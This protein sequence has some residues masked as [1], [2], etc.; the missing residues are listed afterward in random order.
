[1][2]R[3]ARTWK[4][5]VKPHAVRRSPV[6]TS[7]ARRT[8]PALIVAVLASQC[9]EA[10]AQ[11]TA[12]SAAAVVQFDTEFL[13]AGGGRNVDISRFETGSA[14][15]PGV[16]RVDVQVNGNYVTRMD[17]DF[18]AEADGAEA[19][20]RFDEAM[21][22]RIGVD[23][24]QLGDAVRAQL[25]LAGTRLRIEDAVP[26]ATSRFDFGAQRLD[27][28]VPQVAMLRHARGYVA[29]SNWDA[30]VNAAS[31]GY[32]FNAYR[33]KLRHGQAVTQGYL[34]LNAGLNVAGWR[35]R[36][37]GSYSFDT[38]GRRDYQAIASYAKREVTALSAELTVGEAF[39][40]GEL[41]DAVGFRGIRL[42]TDDRMLPESRRGY[43]PTVRGVAN[44]NA[45]VRIRQGGTLIHETTVAAGAF[46]IDD[47][48]A[49]GYGGDLEVT[50]QEADGSQRTFSVPF[51]AVPLSLR[52]GV[53]RFSATLGTLRQAQASSAPVFA[54]ATWQRGLSNQVTGYAGAT[55]ARDYAAGMLG[56][57]LNTRFGA[58]GADITRSSTQTARAGTVSGASYRLSYARD[59]AAT[60]TNVSI[61]AYR[62]STGGFYGLGDAMQ[63]REAARR[64]DVWEPQRQRNRASLTLGQRLGERH[65]R[66]YATASLSDYWNRT[67]SDVNYSLGYSG[68]LGRMSY[69]VSANRQ[70]AADGRAD[71]QYYASLTV[72]LGGN[73][74][75]RTLSNNVSYS[76]AGRSRVQSTLSGT[77][78]E[79]NQ[80]AYGMSLARTH[81]ANGNNDSDL[82]A[83][84]LYR[85]SK[86]DL[87]ASMALGSHYSQASVG[88]RGALVI[89]PGGWTLS[90]PL[91]ET[92][93]IVEV[94]DAQGARLLNAAGVQVD[95]RGY[96]VVPYLTPYR[97]N[98]IS[99]D[100][101]GLSTDVALKL[102]SQ[103]VTPRAGAVAMVRF[104]TESGRSAVL[105]VRRPDGSVL[106]FG[107]N[108][109][110]E[111]DKEVGVVGQGGRI[112]VR[113]LHDQGTLT[114]R[115]ADHA[116]ALCHIDYVLP[117]RG[118]RDAGIQVIGGQCV[119]P[120]V[121]AQAPAVTSPWYLGGEE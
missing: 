60:G 27:V 94:A 119:E 16:Y 41:F 102:N 99:I 70:H 83:N 31:L 57:A 62:Y 10:M 97:A 64:S 44:S 98:T 113:G 24:A 13:V 81:G 14:V 111:Q 84:L 61:A 73:G 19:V 74:R 90:Q 58:V 95:G 51:A 43:A 18:Q 63:A 77:A 49:T 109:L 5:E 23:V 92:F 30:G 105:E 36:H 42:E 25:A 20:A 15:P 17:M 79:S 32:S 67:G 112:F 93:G 52:P 91:S 121:A 48:Y 100:P 116:R 115:W 101:K 35:L 1:M 4:T 46:E 26:D 75:S 38:Q 108:V 65:G 104:A 66:V 118:G 117:A 88:A 33:Q 87:Q 28:S 53:S 59:I 89:H 8:L 68:M 12:M 103:Q 107:A 22:A 85:A 55:A 69:G 7:P 72:P 76:D 6:V 120:P 29:P 2:G 82:G 21:L 50:I 86:A 9:L 114:V 110:D 80:L 11:E 56:V 47:L 40:G 71:T 78:G 34:G 3:L 54:Q 37:E 96:A 106:P 39:T 45:R